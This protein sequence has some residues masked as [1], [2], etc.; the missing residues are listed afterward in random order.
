MKQVSIHSMEPE[1]RRKQNIIRTDIN[2]LATII[3]KNKERG[4]E[5]LYF[6]THTQM[7]CYRDI[8]IFK[9]TFDILTM[10]QQCAARDDL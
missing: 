1:K 6:H 4:S 3:Q 9:K 5:K 2:S 10:K 8:K 7:S